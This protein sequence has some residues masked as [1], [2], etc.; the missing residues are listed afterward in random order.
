MLRR[1]AVLT[2]ALL[3]ATLAACSLDDD[4][5]DPTEV[6][7][8]A[9]LDV[10]LDRMTRSSSGLYY[11]DTTVGTGDLAAAGDQ[12]DVH[13]TGWLWNGTEFDSSRDGGDPLRFTIGVTSIILGFAEGV[14]GM[15][16]GGTRKLVIP[17]ELAYGRNGFRSIPPNAVLVF[18][19]ELVAIDPI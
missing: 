2:P 10:D 18:E 9:S 15:R 6:E 19:I 12:V 7:F 8:A 1:A 5:L 4:I 16:V 13:Y 17:S 11:E 3:L 14:V